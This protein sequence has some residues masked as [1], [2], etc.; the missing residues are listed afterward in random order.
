MA[1]PDFESQ[2]TRLFSEAPPFPDAELFAAQVAA[3]LD[4]G[5]ALRRVLI[6][7]AG[8]AAGVVA[9]A[10]IAASRF[11]SELQTLSLDGAR[12]VS[13]DIDAALHKFNQLVATPAS[14]EALWLVAG[15]AALAL[16]FAVTRAMEE[17]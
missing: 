1:E 6:G 11:S 13:A 16:A 14:V 8:V 3:S 17:F 5:W 4:R 9:A 12:G 10:Q 2:L 15:L 7:G